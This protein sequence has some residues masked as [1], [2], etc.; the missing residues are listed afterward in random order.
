MVNSLNLSGMNEDQLLDL[1]KEKCKVHD[2]TFQ[3][4]NGKSYYDGLAKADEIDY[5][6]QVLGGMD[7]L[8]PATLIIESF[9]PEA[10]KTKGYL[11]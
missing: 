5:I 8:D 2:W 11:V 3:M 7:C 10:L 1:L 9:K 6:R 4:T